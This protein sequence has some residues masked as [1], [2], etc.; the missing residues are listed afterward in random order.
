MLFAESLTTE[1]FLL[2]FFQCS[3]IWKITLILANY[4]LF[5]RQKLLLNSR[6]HKC[7]AMNS[8]IFAKKLH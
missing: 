6:F 2:E 8:C 7:D 4:I 3:Y 1:H 5:L